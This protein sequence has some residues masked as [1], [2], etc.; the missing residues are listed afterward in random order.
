M[1]LQFLLLPIRDWNVA[2]A[3]ASFQIENCNF[4]Y[5]L[6]GIETSEFCQMAEFTKIAISITP[7]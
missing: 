7:Y 6:L 1:L 4:Y 2:L 3:A 5:S